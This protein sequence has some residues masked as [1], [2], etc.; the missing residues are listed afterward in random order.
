MALNRSIVSTTPAIAAR[1]DRRTS[2]HAQR[3]QEE[4]G[5]AVARDVTETVSNAIIIV[6]HHFLPEFAQSPEL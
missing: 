4:A 3:L 1:A 2:L 6:T 5:R